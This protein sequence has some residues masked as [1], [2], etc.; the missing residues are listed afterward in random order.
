MLE[1]TTSKLYVYICP[2]DLIT[3]GMVQ[4]IFKHLGL[5]ADAEIDEVIAKNA[6]LLKEGFGFSDKIP[7]TDW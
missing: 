3:K 5:S 4:F 6:S 7:T 1:P 2:S